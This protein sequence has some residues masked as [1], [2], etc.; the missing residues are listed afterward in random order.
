GK[1]IAPKSKALISE[2]AIQKRLSAQSI[3]QTEMLM[4][5]RAGATGKLT[6]MSKVAKEGKDK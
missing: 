5:A 4:A 1:H 6:I 2:K 3:V